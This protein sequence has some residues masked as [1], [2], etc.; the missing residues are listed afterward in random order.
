MIMKCTAIFATFLFLS[1][2]APA[3]E[4]GKLLPRWQEGYL[5]IHHINTGHGDAAFYV[6]PDGTTM[7]LDAGEMDP[8]SERT[9]SP[10]NA[11]LHPNDS[12]RAHEWIVDYI[13]RFHPVASN[14]VIDYA[15]ITH[16]TAITLEVIIRALKSLQMVIITYLVLQ[17]W[18][19]ILGSKKFLTAAILIT[20]IPCHSRPIRSGR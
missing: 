9:N 12:K 16:F 2:V 14:P 5:D 8:T 3:Q 18:A 7:L 10:R 20:T 6:L 17:V 1:V 19:I 11:K 15:V 4:T 13:K